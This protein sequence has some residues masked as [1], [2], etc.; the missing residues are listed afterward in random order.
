MNFYWL[1]KEE[2]DEGLFS[3]NTK[4]N[5]SKSIFLHYEL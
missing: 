4:P 3:Q 2:K 1:K 5:Q